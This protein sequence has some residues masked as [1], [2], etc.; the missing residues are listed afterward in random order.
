VVSLNFECF[1]FTYPYS[2]HIYPAIPPINRVI[3]LGFQTNSISVGIS[4]VIPVSV[5]IRALV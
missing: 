5:G 1:L 2:K 3:N 4:V